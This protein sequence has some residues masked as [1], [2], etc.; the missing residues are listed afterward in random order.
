MPITDPNCSVARLLC[1]VET[2][3][4]LPKRPVTDLVIV[5]IYLDGHSKAR[6]ECRV[7]LTEHGPVRITGA[8]LRDRAA[9]LL[10]HPMIGVAPPGHVT[11]VN[12]ETVLW[13]DTGAQR[14]L[15]TVTVLGQRVELRARIDH[16]A[17]DFGDGTTATTT[18]PGRAYTDADPC[19]S[20]QCRDYFGHTYRATGKVTI[21]ADI[22][23]RGQFRL[24][25][26]AWQPIAGTVTAA[27]T[28]TSVDVEQARAVLVPDP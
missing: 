21:A 20:A 8:M 19:D 4:D 17:W 6:P 13:A 12:I 16:V 11:L 26:G 1:D 9:K 24:A 7:P 25:G 23:W 10:P 28:A 18:S 27:A 2:E 22:A 5:S 15:G 3:T 14:N